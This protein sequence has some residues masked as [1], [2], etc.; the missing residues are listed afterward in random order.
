MRPGLKHNGKDFTLGPG[1]V[2]CFYKE[3]RL[4]T[5]MPKPG[6]GEHVKWHNGDDKRYIDNVRSDKDFFNL[7]SLL[8]DIIGCRLEYYD[9]PYGPAY[10]FT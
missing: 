10:L 8:A 7:I 5:I 6:T 2:I 3:E 9:W 4:I 1:S